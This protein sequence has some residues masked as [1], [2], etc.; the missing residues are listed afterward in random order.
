MTETVPVE[1][2]GGDTMSM[3]AWD[4]DLSAGMYTSGW[5]KRVTG[6]DLTKPS[7]FGILGDFLKKHTNSSDNHAFYSGADREGT[8]F[9]LGGT[10]GARYRQT[11]SNCLVVVKAGGKLDYEL[12]DQRYKGNNLELLVKNNAKVNVQEII[13]KF[14]AL[15]AVASSGMFGIL[16]AIYES[17]LGKS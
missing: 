6:L 12:R 1:V 9:F 13:D 10:G 11:K 14:P 8:L 7:G 17:Q 3:V 15:A 5:A 2:K 4:M 16:A